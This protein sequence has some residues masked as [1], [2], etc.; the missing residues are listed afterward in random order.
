[1]NK[2]EFDN[3]DYLKRTARNHFWVNGEKGQLEI[4]NLKVA[5]AGLGGMGSGIALSLARLGVRHFKIADNDT[6]ELSNLNRQVVANTTT[7]GQTKAEITK[8]M[9]LEIDPS[10]GVEVYSEGVQAQMIAEFLN[11]VDVIVDEID[12]YPIEAHLSLHKEAAKRKIDIYSSYV[13][14]MGIHIYR[15]SHP[16]YQLQDFYHPDCFSEEKRASGIVKTYLRPFP[17][18]LKGKRLEI[19]NQEVEMG[20]VPIFGPS[21]LL[22]HSAIATRLILDRLNLTE[23]PTPIMPNYINIDLSNF[24]IEN[25]RFSNWE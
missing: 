3:T 13:I 22:G 21:C 14:G 10:I 20:K 12:V 19:F 1:M 24:T 9:L 15:F 17:P 16:H 5:I 6:I 2:K 11:D 8:K 7:I 23:L 4:G 25:Y 18:Y